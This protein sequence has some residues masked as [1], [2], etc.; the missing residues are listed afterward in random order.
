MITLRTDGVALLRPE[1]RITG[2]PQ[3]DCSSAKPSRN[4]A[5]TGFPR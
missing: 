3:T 1:R 5:T 2:P 4:S